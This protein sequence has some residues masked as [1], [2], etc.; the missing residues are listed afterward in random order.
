MSRTTI[1]G[2]LPRPVS[3]DGEIVLPIA[4][5]E[6]IL[7]WEKGKIADARLASDEMT[8]EEVDGVDATSCECCVWSGGVEHCKPIRCGTR[9]P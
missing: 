7:V 5:N 2:T 6:V 3:G 4:N 1:H 9:C 8:L